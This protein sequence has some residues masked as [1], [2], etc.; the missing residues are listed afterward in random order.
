VTLQKSKRLEDATKGDFLFYLQSL[1]YFVGS[2][3][4]GS[5]IAEIRLIP[6]GSVL[7]ILSIYRTKGGLCTIKASGHPIL[8]S[9]TVILIDNF[10]TFTYEEFIILDKN[11]KPEIKILYDEIY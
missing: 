11:N 4:Y 9:P 3:S 8:N 6:S 7:E 5:Q 1:S 10:K 2:N